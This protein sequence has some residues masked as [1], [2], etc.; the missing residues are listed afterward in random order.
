MDETGRPAA[1]A[2]EMGVDER[3]LNET[4]LVVGILAPCSMPKT[5]ATCSGCAAR[6]P[7][8]V[9]TLNLENSVA[10]GLAAGEHVLSDSHAPKQTHRRSAQPNPDQSNRRWPDGRGSSVTV[11]VTD[12]GCAYEYPDGVV[13][14]AVR[15]IYWR[16]RHIRSVRYSCHGPA[17]S[18]A[19]NAST[20]RPTTWRLRSIPLWPTPPT[21]TVST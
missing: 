5:E 17:Y 8:Y 14:Q 19:G 3:L 18:Y 2:A 10:E 6:T 9:W 7:N 15:R 13:V 21:V 12:R 16:N 4:A 20:M 11:V 1:A